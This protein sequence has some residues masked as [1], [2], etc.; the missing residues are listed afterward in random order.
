MRSGAAFGR[1]TD[2][3][4]DCD[5]RIWWSLDSDST[6]GGFILPADLAD[7]ISALGVDIHATVYL[8]EGEE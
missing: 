2:L 6:Q 7:S 4:T 1:V 3:P 8:D 5:A